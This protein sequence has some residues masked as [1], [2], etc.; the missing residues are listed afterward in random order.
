MSLEIDNANFMITQIASNLNCMEIDE[1][2]EPINFIIDVGMIKQSLML[3][4][5]GK[6]SEELV[7]KLYNT[8]IVDHQETITQV[9]NYEV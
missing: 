2:N 7:L 4:T 1:L 6:V 5:F 9:L 3:H 8:F